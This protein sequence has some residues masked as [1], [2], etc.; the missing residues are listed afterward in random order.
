M[1]QQLEDRLGL[2]PNAPLPLQLTTKASSMWTE[3][4]H[5]DTSSWKAK[6]HRLGERLM[7][8]I[9]CEEWSLKAV[10][11]GL[12]PPGLVQV[13]VDETDAQGRERVREAK[14]LQ[15]DDVKARKEVVRSPPP[16]PRGR[17]RRARW[18]RALTGVA[19]TRGCPPGPALLPAARRL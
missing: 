4:G 18:V 12:V 16:R 7:D 10:E 6:A 11:R 1:R 3:L 15:K 5:A 2:L 13:A 8:R 9:E 14:T 19:R 17:P